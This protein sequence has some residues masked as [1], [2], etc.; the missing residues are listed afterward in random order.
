MNNFAYKFRIYPNKEQRNFINKNIGACRFIYNLLLDRRFVIY[1]KAKSLPEERRKKI[2]Y[3]SYARYREKYPWI[4]EVDSNGLAFEQR[5]LM[6]AF[7][8]WYRAIRLNNITKAGEC[9]PKFKSR[10]KKKSYTTAGVSTVIV[11]DKHIKIAKLKDP[12]KAVIHRE[13]KGRIVS[14]TISRTSSNKYYISLICEDEIERKILNKSNSIISINLGLR[15]YITFLKS[16]NE[17]GKFENPK[18]LKKYQNRIDFYNKELS[19]RKKGGQNWKKTKIKINKI[20]E[21]VANTRNYFLN[22]ITTKIIKEN[23]VIII[24]DIKVK[25][26]SKKIKENSNCNAQSKNINRNLLDIGI[27]DFRRMLEYKAEMYGRKVII[28]KDYKKL[29]KICS[30]CGEERET[31]TQI[32]DNKWKCNKCNTVQDRNIN[33]LKNLMKEGLK[34]YG[35]K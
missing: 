5:H 2:I 23:D 15:Q 34:I 22:N 19:R 16:N 28:V 35:E 1:E 11:D 9:K 27:Y 10:S 12:I 17:T 25:E 13:V 26:E 30:N 4:K 24:P 20:Y 31:N 14:A 7:N 32:I 18:I 3:P 29:D 6:Q 8:N 21:K 33:I